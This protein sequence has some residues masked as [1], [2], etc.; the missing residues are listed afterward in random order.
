M[1][2]SCNPKFFAVRHIHYPV[3]T[4]SDHFHTDAAT[5]TLRTKWHTNSYLTEEHR[6]DR[7]P[8]ERLDRQRYPDDQGFTRAFTAAELDIG[9]RVLKNG[10]APGLDDIQTELI[11]Q[12]GP[13]ARDWLLRFFNNCTATKKIP[14]L[15]RQ[16]KVVALLKPGKDPSVAKSIRPNSLLCHTYKLFERLILNRIAEHVDAKLVPEQA[17][18]RPGKSCTSQLL[19]LTEHIEDGYEKRL[20]T[21]A[22]FVD[23]SAAYDTVNH[24]RLLSKVLEM[25]GD[26]QLTDLIRTMLE[27]IRFFVVLNGK[28][29]RWRQRRNGLPQGS[30]LAPML[31]NIYT[32]DQPIHT[33]THSFIYA[34]DLR[35]ASQGNEFNNIDTQV[36]PE[37]YDHHATT[38]QT[39]CVRTL[40]RHR[41]VLST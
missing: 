26:V 15:W 22:V 24:R 11:K 12:F 41:C 31:F 13:K 1:F 34:D 21:G 39:N 35:I 5:S 10:K 40:Q 33:D 3:N 7:Q 38:T 28:K 32:N 8:K 27:N 23:L 17:G 37:H 19:N 9:I 29:S 20:I 6:T 14:K 2:F 25:T 4:P 18:F 30:V 36:C 16:A